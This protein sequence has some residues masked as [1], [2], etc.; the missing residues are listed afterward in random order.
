MLPKEKI[1]STVFL[2][3]AMILGNIYDGLEITLE[4]IL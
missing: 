4:E 1:I 3:K 2:K